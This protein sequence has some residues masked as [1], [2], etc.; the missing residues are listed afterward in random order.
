[1][2]LV[3]SRPRRSSSVKLVW[4]ILQGRLA[5]HGKSKMAATSPTEKRLVFFYPSLPANTQSYRIIFVK[6]SMLEK[7]LDRRFLKTR[8]D[9]ENWPGEKT[10]P[11]LLNEIA[12]EK[13][14]SNPS[15][16]YYSYTERS[17]H[18]LKCI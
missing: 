11:A 7:F 8:T 12:D 5:N 15:L 3:L 1:M 10:V 4:R 18:R 6:E 9:S 13:I 2:Y 14:G 17:C 16:P